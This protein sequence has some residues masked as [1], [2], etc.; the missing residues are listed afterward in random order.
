MALQSDG[1]LGFLMEEQTYCTTSG[2]GYTI[3]Y[4]R[5][6]IEEVTDGQYRGLR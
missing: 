3:V 6:T 2:G 1:A 4:D 5:F